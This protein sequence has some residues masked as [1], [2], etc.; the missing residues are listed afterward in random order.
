MG[1][2]DPRVGPRHKVEKERESVTGGKRG[3]LC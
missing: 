3:R 2:S 1:L